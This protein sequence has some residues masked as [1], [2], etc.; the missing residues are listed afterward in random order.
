MRTG[1]I[2][3]ERKVQHRADIIG[4]A[5]GHHDHVRENSHVAKIKRAVMRRA[6]VGRQP[7][8]IQHESHR[9]ILQADFLENL[10]VAALQE[11]AVNV[12]DRSQ[13]DF[14]LTGRKRDGVRF[15][16]S[17]VEEAIGKLFADGFKFVALAHGRRDHRD[18]LDCAAFGRRIAS[19]A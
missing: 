9:Q 8:A 2:V 18:A 10:V 6:V 11:R 1:R 4:I 15:A 7:A 12:H 14:G 16:D 13:A 19:R 3:A 17:D 5:G